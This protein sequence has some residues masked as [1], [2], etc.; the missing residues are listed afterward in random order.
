[1]LLAVAGCLVLYVSGTLGQLL[2][3]RDGTE[4]A[5]EKWDFVARSE[6]ASQQPFEPAHL[7]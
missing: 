3:I 7:F 5:E 1:M 2:W 6:S 4:H